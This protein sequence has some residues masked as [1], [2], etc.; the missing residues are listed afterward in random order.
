MMNQDT[1]AIVDLYSRYAENF[2]DRIGRLTN[3][4]QSYTDFVSS[5]PRNKKLLDLAC[6]PGNVSYFIQRLLPGVEVTCVDLSEKMLDLAR[7]KLGE[8]AFVKSDILEV[9][10]PACP[11]DMVVCAF[12][13]P[14]VTK[15]DVPR[16]VSQIQRFTHEQT[17]VYISCMKGDKRQLEP[18]SFAG[19]EEIEVNY[20]DKEFLVKCFTHGGFKLDD[21]RELEYQETDGATTIDMVMRFKA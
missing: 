4:D 9:N 14:Y 19:S 3:Y 8:G 10:L 20:H 12:G 16:L 21:Y 2:D 7:K 13:L 17:S 18:M 11:Y 5:S 1:Q 6:G 15:E